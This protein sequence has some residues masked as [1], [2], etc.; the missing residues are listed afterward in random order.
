MPM[1]LALQAASPLVHQALDLPTYL[2]VSDP[3]KS[4]WL[5]RLC[6]DAAKVIV[7]QLVPA[8]SSDDIRH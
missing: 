2:S 7:G 8:W 5:S 3:I 6:C 1:S 4:G